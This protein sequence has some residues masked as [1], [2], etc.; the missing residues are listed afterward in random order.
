MSIETDYLVIG[1]GGM[2][3]AFADAVLTESDANAASGVLN[4]PFSIAH[5]HCWR[6]AVH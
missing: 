6:V 4:I 5:E 3:M 2:G 1:A